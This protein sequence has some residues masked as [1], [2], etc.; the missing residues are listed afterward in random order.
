MQGGDTFQLFSTAVSGFTATNLPAL[1]GAMYWTNKLALN[2]SIAVVNP[3]N[4]NRPPLL[5]SF[6][7]TTLTLSWPTNSGWTLQMQANS[8]SVGVSNNWVDVPG[9]TTIT[10]T[11]IVVNPALPTVFYRLKY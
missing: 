9:S 8:L 11:N 4:T 1:T 2:G 6:N 5:S 3:I 7:G 10:T